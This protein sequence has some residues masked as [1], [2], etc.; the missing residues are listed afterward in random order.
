M[1]RKKAKPH[2]SSRLHVICPFCGNQA[3]KTANMSWC[4][5]C[6]VEYYT[7]K[8]GSVWFD[9]ERETDRFLY[10]KAIQQSGGFSMGKLLRREE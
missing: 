9:T 2:P 10:G 3:D 4:S 6:G 5:E 8:S 7:T 1:V